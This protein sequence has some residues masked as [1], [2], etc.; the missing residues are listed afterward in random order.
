ME[1]Q[2]IQKKNWEQGDVSTEAGRP[3]RRKKTGVLRG[4]R[5]RRWMD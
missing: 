1:G 5:E 4:K 3:K 2:R